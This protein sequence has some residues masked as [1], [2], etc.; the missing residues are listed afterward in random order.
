MDDCKISHV[1]T[2]VVDETISL[3]KADFEII[4]EDGLGASRYIGIGARSTRMLV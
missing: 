1:S 3:L 4:F 2:S